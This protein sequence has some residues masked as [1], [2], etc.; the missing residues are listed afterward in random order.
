MKKHGVAV[1]VNGKKCESSLSLCVAVENGVTHIPPL[2]NGNIRKA[3]LLIIE[4]MVWNTSK[5]C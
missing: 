1:I 2:F 4:G 5:V 3:R